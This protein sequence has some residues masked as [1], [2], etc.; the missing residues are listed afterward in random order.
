M[1]PYTL[2]CFISI[3]A[4]GMTCSSRNS[5]ARGSF[6]SSA[7]RSI[8]S[9]TINVNGISGCQRRKKRERYSIDPQENPHT[10]R[11]C[12]MRGKPVRFLR[13]DKHL[14]ALFPIHPHLNRNSKNVHR[15]RKICI[16]QSR[17]HKT[18]RKMQSAR[19]H[20][21]PNDERTNADDLTASGGYKSRQSSNDK[22]A[23]NSGV[24]YQHVC[25]VPSV[26]R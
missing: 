4:P 9:G 20:A 14:F 17:C 7:T 24:S 2:R 16:F 10:V 6:P 15:R 19:M 12:T 22:E 21:K 5:R 23:F 25:F 11:F 1:F 26:V 18:G 13:A 3:N 8:L